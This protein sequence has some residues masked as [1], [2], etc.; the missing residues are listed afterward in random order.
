MQDF[1]QIQDDSHQ[2]DGQQSPEKMSDEDLAWVGAPFEDP[3][4]PCEVIPPI[5][6]DLFAR[7]LALA[8]QDA[9]TNFE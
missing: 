7:E 4:T 2:A 6:R 1:S 9:A 5:M 3:P 8:M